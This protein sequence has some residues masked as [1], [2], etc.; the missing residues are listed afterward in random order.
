MDR[1]ITIYHQLPEELPEVRS[2]WLH[3]AFTCIH[4]FED[5][6]GRVARAL[7]SI[8][9]IRAGMFP[10]LIDRTDKHSEYIPALECADAGDLGKLVEFFYKREERVGLRAISLAETAVEQSEGMDKIL[11]AASAKIVQRRTSQKNERDLM[12]SRMGQLAGLAN[13]QFDKTASDVRNKVDGCRASVDRSS[14]NT[15]HYFRAQ[16][17]ELAKQRGYWAD[18]REPWEWIRLKLRDGGITDLVLVIHFIGNPS[19]GA[20][21]ATAF[22]GHRTTPEDEFLA[23]VIPLDTETLVLY[24]AEDTAVQRKRFES[25]LEGITKTALAIWIKYL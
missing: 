1:L 16:I 20:C 6:N 19:P 12:R 25:W 3:H 23:E 10:L 15:G 17:V 18:L 11:E 4:P 2:A 21:V 24:P 7:A 8:D 14:T 13:A 9:F 5:K 22:M